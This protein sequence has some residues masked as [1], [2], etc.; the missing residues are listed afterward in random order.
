MPMLTLVGHPNAVNPDLG[1]RAEARSRGWPVY[2][3]RSGRRVT[4]IAL[5]IAAGA[6]AL[7][8]GMA[9]GAALQRR[10]AAAR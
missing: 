4:M 8:G 6:G 5:P 9:A 3:F 10:R 1:L 7:A 2:D